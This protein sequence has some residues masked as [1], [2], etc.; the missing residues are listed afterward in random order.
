MFY[1]LPISKDKIFD[2][3]VIDDEFTKLKSL[4]SNRAWE[5]LLGAVND[6]MPLC[7][8]ELLVS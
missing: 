6:T 2:I 8:S 4:G 1:V 7:G 5:I 3:R